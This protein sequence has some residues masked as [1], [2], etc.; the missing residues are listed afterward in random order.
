MPANPGAKRAAEKQKKKREAARKLAEQARA[1]AKDREMA[2]RAEAGE[3]AADEG[4][5]RA[6]VDYDEL[7]RQATEV[8]KLLKKNA[9]TEA[10]KICAEM[11]RAHPDQPDGWQCFALVHEARG[12]FAKAVSEMERAASR[13]SEDDDV[14]AAKIKKELERLRAKAK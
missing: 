6:P 10:A 4:P 7:D 3:A 5:V 8:P 9:I 1:R 13:V 14:T 2:A 11:I 12:D